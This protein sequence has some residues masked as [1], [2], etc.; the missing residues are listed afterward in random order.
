MTAA[1]RL[2]C[3]AQR[4]A[5]RNHAP[6]RVNRTVVAVVVPAVVVRKAAVVVR[7]AA[8][9]VHKVA[10]V[11]HKVAVVVHKVVA[12]VVHKVAVAPVVADRAQR[13]VVHAV[14]TDNH[15]EGRTEKS[16]LFYERI[17]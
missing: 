15:F 2:L 8:V 13:R 9:V 6:H 10:V 17:T 3:H 7:K 5:R 14:V 11:V 4:H 16:A 1:K 12:A